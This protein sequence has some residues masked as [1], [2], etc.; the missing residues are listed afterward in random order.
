MKFCYTL[1]EK[2]VVKAMQLHGKGTRKVLAALIALGLAIIAAGAVAGHVY[3]ALAA[4]ACG[5]L[6][7][8]A[9]LYLTIPFNARKQFRENR[10]IRNEIAVDATQDGVSFKSDS[11]ES[12]LQWSDIH[13]W[14]GGNGIYLLY[15]TS[16][17]FHI[18][19]ARAIPAE[20]QWVELLSTHVGPGRV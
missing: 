19:P 10:A 1:D 6:G 5:A 16:H 3:L 13:R 7:Y 18:V 12:R 20:P 8:F 11:G 14:K 2:E 15:V 4:V 17:M 9:V